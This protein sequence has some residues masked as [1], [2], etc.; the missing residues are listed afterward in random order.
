MQRIGLKSLF[1][2]RPFAAAA[3]D[4]D[5]KMYFI[6]KPENA[7]AF[8]MWLDEHGRMAGRK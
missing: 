2:R 5:L 8:L 7:N 3:Y 6:I 4:V 1:E